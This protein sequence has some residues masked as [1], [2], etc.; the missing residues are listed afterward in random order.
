[1]DKSFGLL[2]KTDSHQMACLMAEY[3][4]RDDL[5]FVSF[6]TELRASLACHS[7]LHLNMKPGVPKLAKT[8]CVGAEL[9]FHEEHTNRITDTIFRRPLRMRPP[10]YGTTSVKASGKS[11]AA[12]LKPKFPKFK[13]MPVAE[14]VAMVASIA[15]AALH[16]GRNFDFLVEIFNDTDKSK[17]L[18]EAGTAMDIIKSLA[19]TAPE[20]F[21]QLVSRENPTLCCTLAPAVN[22]AVKLFADASH[23]FKKMA[24]DPPLPGDDYDGTEDYMSLFWIPETGN[25]NREIDM[26]AVVAKLRSCVSPVYER[27]KLFGDAYLEFVTAEGL[28]QLASNT[29]HHSR[30]HAYVSRART[31]N[32]LLAD[33]RA[34]MYTQTE[35]IG[36][37]DVRTLIC[38]GISA[39]QLATW[40]TTLGLTMRGCAYKDG[41][42]NGMLWPHH[43]LVHS[44]ASRPVVHSQGRFLESDLRSVFRTHL[45]QS[46][47]GTVTWDAELGETQLSDF[48]SPW[49]VR[50]AVDL[51]LLKVRSGDQMVCRSRARHLAELAVA[52]YPIYALAVEETIQVTVG[53]V[54]TL[55]GVT[56]MCGSRPRVTLET[57]LTLGICTS[58]ATAPCP[59]LLFVWRVQETALVS[60]RPGLLTPRGRPVPPAHTTLVGVHRSGLWN[61]VQPYIKGIRG[62]KLHDPFTVPKHT[63]DN[64]HTTQELARAATLLRLAHEKGDR[65]A[66]MSSDSVG[67]VDYVEWKIGTLPAFAAMCPAE[68]N[69]TP[70]RVP[71]PLITSLADHLWSSRRL[72]EYSAGRDRVLGRCFLE[73]KPTGYSHSR[74][75][76]GGW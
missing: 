14:A 1:M 38:H 50:V 44:M 63:E 23:P 30:Q 48:H 26:A 66:S 47:V 8:T 2:A 16:R 11:F 75:R 29:G 69:K 42:F 4:A 55:T 36:E 27:D 28:V 59:T 68:Q 15:R 34:S 22:Y 74:K 10:V 32:G 53:S 64:P 41:A 31:P 45:L 56:Q 72:D 19:A 51:C 12:M 17:E 61:Y 62:S 54:E 39:R 9:K 6:K 20:E 33:I 57:A 58:P 25:T 40:L 73:A 13:K 52:V 70:F 43:E 49:P 35:R 46:E 37:D 18:I 21:N 3:I 71:L 67:E 24:R 65:I 60:P 5:P 7:H 76:C